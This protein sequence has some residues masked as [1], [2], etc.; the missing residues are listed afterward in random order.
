[1]LL[2]LSEDKLREIKWMTLRKRSEIIS[3]Q[4]WVSESLWRHVPYRSRV[5]IALFAVAFQS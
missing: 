5:F 1:M 3:V 4:A 2:G